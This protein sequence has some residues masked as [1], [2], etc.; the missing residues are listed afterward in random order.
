M[1][2]IS[3]IVEVLERR[4][5]A[6]V[7]LQKSVSDPTQRDELARAIA[8]TD[9]AL[10]KLQVPPASAHDRK[11]ASRGYVDGSLIAYSKAIAPILRNLVDPLNRKMEGIERRLAAIEA[12]TARG[13]SNVDP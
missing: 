5:A 13:D 1:T 2:D 3:E 9:V 4:R 7:T 8:D 12:K 11:P 6:F 10:E